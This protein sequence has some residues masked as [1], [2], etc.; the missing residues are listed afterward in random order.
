M[1]CGGAGF[2]EAP[3]ND[4]SVVGSITAELSGDRFTAA[5]LTVGSDVT[6]GNVPAGLAQAVT[7]IPVLVIGRPIQQLR[8]MNGSLS[9]TAMVCL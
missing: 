3:A 6:L 5:T 2:T 7:T 4:G 9:P 1:V 8:P